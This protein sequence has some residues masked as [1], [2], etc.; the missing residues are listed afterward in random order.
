[1]H[2][3]SLPE[4]CRKM[5][6]R[7]FAESKSEK[8]LRQLW[9]G[10]NNN[11]NWQND[12]ADIFL[13]LTLATCFNGDPALVDAAYR[14]SGLFNEKWDGPYYNENVTYGA[15]IV[16]MVTAGFREYDDDNPRSFE[17]IDDSSF[18]DWPDPFPLDDY[19]QLP[20]YP[21]NAL[22]GPCGKMACAGTWCHLQVLIG[23]S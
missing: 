21:I 6:D 23:R 13:C 5:V 9:I 20:K 18:G 19:S 15:K 14:Q 11:P 12:E 2:N 10:I 8:T 22:L 1:M 4:N 3:N 16:E 7:A 17:E